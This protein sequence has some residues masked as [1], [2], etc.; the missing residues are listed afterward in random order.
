MLP[1]VLFYGLAA[2]L[3]FFGI[4]RLTYLGVFADKRRPARPTPQGA[5]TDVPEDDDDGETIDD[6]TRSQRYRR[7]PRMG[8]GLVS[9]MGLGRMAPAKRHTVMGGLWIVLGLY[10]AWTGFNLSRQQHAATEAVEDS[11]P[12]RV[13]RARVGNSTESAR[14]AE[15][16]SAPAELKPAPASNE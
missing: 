7:P 10:M 1:P 6:E 13:I 16:P 4:L 14:P 9:L 2:A 5:Q 12:L 8:F 15:Q 3:L 11:A